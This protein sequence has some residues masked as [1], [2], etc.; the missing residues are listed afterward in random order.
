MF[1]MGKIQTRKIVGTIIFFLN[2]FSILC[3]LL[4]TKI[5]GFTSFSTLIQDASAFLTFIC[6]VF[7]IIEIVGGD[8]YKLVLLYIADIVLINRLYSNI[9]WLE[10]IR[11][12]KKLDKGM[13][14][15]TIIMAVIVLY[16]IYTLTIKYTKELK[17]SRDNVTEQVQEDTTISMERIQ[18]GFGDFSDFLKKLCVG[19]VVWGFFDYIVYS[20]DIIRIK[21]PAGIS[22]MPEILYYGAV[23]CTVILIVLSFVKRHNEEENTDIYAVSAFLSLGFEVFVIVFS[24]KMDLTGMVGDFLTVL[25]ENWFVTLIAIVV[26]FMVIQIC[27]SILLSL[28]FPKKNIN[29]LGEQFHKSIMHIEERMVELACNIIEGC[30]ELMGFIPD[31]FTF[32]GALL[33][34]EKIKLEEWKSMDLTGTEEGRNRINKK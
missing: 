32:I 22:W 33:L 11:K 9:K 19:V 17:K 27:I 23:I 1:Q 18:K 25:S 4:K 10:I 6:I 31:F 3:D 24:K 13:I 21:R 26:F 20:Q 29:K 14:I 12:I 16:V 15:L 2:F 30:I 7:I 34:D 5:S 28:L 8:S